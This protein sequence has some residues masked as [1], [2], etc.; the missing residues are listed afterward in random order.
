MYYDPNLEIARTAILTKHNGI[1]SLDFVEEQLPPGWKKFMEYIFHLTNRVP[2]CS[3]SYIG[4]ERGLLRIRAVSPVQFDEVVFNW[5]AEY[6]AKQSASVCIICGEKGIRR[7][8]EE[9]WPC[10]CSVHQIQWVNFFAGRS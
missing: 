7:K 4:V 5:A 1:F 3:V 8:H 9:G 10:L 6:L 2:S